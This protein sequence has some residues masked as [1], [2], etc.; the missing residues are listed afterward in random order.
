MTFNRKHI[1][2][3]TL[4]NRIM[5][6]LFC[7]TLPCK[8]QNLYDEAHSAKF[9][10]YL[11]QSQQFDLASQ[12]YERLFFLNDTNAYYK[13]QLFRSYRRSGNLLLAQK[14]IADILADSLKYA[15]EPVAQEY[16][17]ILMLQNQLPTATDFNR[18]DPRISVTQKQ[19]NLLQI[20]LLSKN[21]KKADSIATLIQS[22]DPAYQKILSSA[23]SM[24]HKYPGLALT[25]SV[26]IPG[27][28]KVYSG[29][30]KDGIV[31]FLFVAAS[32][33]QSYRGFS[34][35]GSSS[36]SGWVWGSISTGF[37]FGNLFGSFKSAKRFNNRQNELLHKHAE[38]YI[39]SS[40]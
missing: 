35:Y 2:F 18:T 10:E 7:I 22:I 31:S 21:W 36:V 25:F 12:E 33:L 23:K 13:L 28:G 26:I 8:A 19:Y 29:A 6:L 39:Y 5:L 11:Y 17:H 37:Y 38:S 20:S 40:F 14:R 30:W 34:R 32:G 9:A 3:M 1:S 27:A 4:F 16:L 15:S 24:K